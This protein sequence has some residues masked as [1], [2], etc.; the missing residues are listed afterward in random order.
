MAPPARRDAP[1]LQERTALRVLRDLRGKPVPPVPRDR[2]ARMDVPVPREKTAPQ[3][4]Q[5][6]RGK[7]GL[8]VLRDRPDVPVPREKSALPGPPELLGPPELPDQEAG[9]ERLVLRGLPDLRGYRE[10]WA[11]RERLALLAPPERL[12]RTALPHFSI[13]NIP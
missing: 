10:T 4:L 6:L 1:V 2:P 9:R 3:V 7:L 5:A 13:R 12:L 11:H 8:Q